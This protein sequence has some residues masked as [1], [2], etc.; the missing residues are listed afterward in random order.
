MRQNILAVYYVG[1]GLF[2]EMNVKVEQG[3]MLLLHDCGHRGPGLTAPALNA[4]FVSRISHSKPV[5]NQ[6]IK[7]KVY[8]FI[9]F[10][11]GIIF[12]HQNS[13]IC[14]LMGG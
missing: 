5:E 14:V 2:T 1:T 11:E 7:K 13:K 12:L 10:Y 9:K 8:I 4:T 3:K 6:S